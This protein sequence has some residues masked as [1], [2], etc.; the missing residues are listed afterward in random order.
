MGVLNLLLDTHCWIWLKADPD[1]LPSPVRRRILRDPSKLVLSSVSVLEI[2]IKHA[3]GRLQLKSD[4]AQLVAELAEDG[5]VSLSTTIEHALRMAALP[6]RHRDPFD[7]LL[8]A[9]TLVE[10][11]TLVTADANVLAYGAP[12]IDARK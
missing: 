4:P 6:L 9:Q 11:L 8:V 12:S 5:V 2:V 10:G 3:T 7:R 1:C